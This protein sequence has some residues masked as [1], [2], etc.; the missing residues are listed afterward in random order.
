MEAGQDLG[1]RNVVYRAIS[2]LH[3]EKG[4]CYRGAELTPEYTHYDAGSGF[5]VDLSKGDFLGRGA[6]LK[7]KEKGPKWKLCSF[8]IDADIPVM[9]RG[10]EPILKDDKVIGLTTSGGYGFTVG[11]TIAYGYI[12][13]EEVGSDGRYQIEVYGEVFP[14]NREPHRA[15]YDPERKKI[16]M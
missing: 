11:K 13:F 14:A 9:L 2:S 1:I 3:F 15:L 5:C 8:T 10:S 12:P 7:V 16:L 6:L 4:Y